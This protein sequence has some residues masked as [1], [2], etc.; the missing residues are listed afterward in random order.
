[1]YLI[2]SKRSG[3]L[4]LRIAS[5]LVV[6]SLKISSLFSKFLCKVEIFFWPN[7]PISPSKEFSFF[8][9]MFSAVET[10]IKSQKN[11]AVNISVVPNPK[12][13]S[14]LPIISSDILLG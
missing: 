4:P 10:P 6:G 1:M 3:L 13:K 14:Q 9:E 7:S 11:C 12:L 2:L 8:I 5:N